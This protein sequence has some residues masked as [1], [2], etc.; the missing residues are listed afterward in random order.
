MII[1]RRYLLLR[2]TMESDS[3]ASPCVI[4]MLAMSTVHDRGLSIVDGGISHMLVVYPVC[5]CCCR[6]PTADDRLP[7][8]HAYGLP[9]KVCEKAND[10]INR[11]SLQASFINM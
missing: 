6:L 7:T 5:C 1:R 2:H 11:I 3:V 9:P 8:V 4:S 10:Y